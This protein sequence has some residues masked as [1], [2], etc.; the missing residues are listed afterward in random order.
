MYILKNKYFALGLVSLVLLVALLPFSLQM[1]F[2][3]NDDWVYYEVVRNFLQ[4][5]FVLHS[6][7]G[8]NLYLQ[9]FMGAV[10]S[11]FFA[12]KSGLAEIARLVT[13]VELVVGPGQHRLFHGLVVLHG[14]GICTPVLLV[15]KL[16]TVVY[17]GL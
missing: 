17:Q 5:N 3:Q 8:P 10:F 7:V 15:I 1:T 12:F 14:H 4:G 11:L 13:V 2:P 9:A 16:V 6:Y